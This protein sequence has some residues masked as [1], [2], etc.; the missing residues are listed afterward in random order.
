MQPRVQA[1]MKRTQ[2]TEKEKEVL[3]PEIL[4]REEESILFVRRIGDYKETSW[5]AFEALVAFLKKERI[6]EEKIKAFYSVG[7]DDPKIVPRLQCR[8]DAG[9]ALYDNVPP[10]GEV[11]RRVLKGGR[12]AVFTHCGPRTEIE[13]TYDAI[14]RIWYPTFK[15]QLSDDPPFC[16]HPDVSD[17]AIPE[18]D[19]V[20][21]FYIPFVER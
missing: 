1:I 17:D 18:N 21:K 3:K 2:S 12:F 11:G 13:N 10:K 7:L 16:E 20:T 8:F 9:V 19:R 6:P 15:D 4:Y 14:F 5:Q